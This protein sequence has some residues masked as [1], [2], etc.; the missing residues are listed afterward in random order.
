MSTERS[1]RD[2]GSLF[3]NKEKRKPSQP[4]MQGDCSIG[5]TP[6]EIRAWRR[7][8]QLTIGVAPPRRDQNTYPPDAFRGAL[9]PVAAKP[10]S[11]RNA[12][13]EPTP[14]WSGEIDGDEARY[15]VQAFEKQGKSGTYFT[16]S[17]ERTEKPKATPPELESGEL[18][19]D[20]DGEPV[21][22]LH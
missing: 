19:T 13:A 4:D 6:Y 16:L 18:E 11:K 15:I 7:E 9:D 3:E 20:D 21:D 2:R 12:D 8:E 10:K 5:G 14:S 17:F 22:S 1:Q